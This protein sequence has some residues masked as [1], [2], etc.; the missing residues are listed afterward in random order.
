MMHAL[1]LGVRLSW[2]PELK[3]QDV[4]DEINTLFYGSAAK[5]MSAYWKYVDD[6]W[7]KTPEYSGCGFGY[8]RR[9]TPERLKESRKLLDAAKK[10]C[11]TDVE[12][13]R[14]ELADDSL[15]LFESFMQLRRDQAEGKFD[16]LA[17]DAAKWR[18][19]VVELGNKWKDNFCFT[20]IAWAEPDTI[21]GRYFASFYQQTYD[22]ASRIAKTHTI[23]TP[24]P[25]RTFAY[26]PD[27][28][29]SGEKK[30]WAKAD[31]DGAKWKTTDVAF[32]TWSSIG[33]H[34]W[35]K[36]MWYRTT[37]DVPAVTKGK[38]VY[39]WLG[40]TDG[41]AKVFV[42]GQHVPYVD[43]KAKKSDEA[44]GYCQPFS[45]DVTSAIKPGAKNSVA[46]L[47]TR[48]FFNELGTGGLLAPVVLYR[49]KD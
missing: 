42:N 23:L 40:S 46:I 38:K 45:F 2:N 34:D 39:L 14:V 22:D 15:R 19:L 28:D 49:E 18:K 1:Y 16:N 5:E 3:S 36:S 4:Y 27:A 37:V 8:L 7:V 33:H 43:A 25:I 9:W 32:E 31:F 48:T 11:K 12:K 13:K 35:F 30:G 10:A 29:K 17:T 6:V 24:K 26:Q 47:C 41:S 21:S 20:K 44:N